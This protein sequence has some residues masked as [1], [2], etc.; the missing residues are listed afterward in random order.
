MATIT[1]TYC[2]TTYDDGT[3]TLH[4]ATEKGNDERNNEKAVVWEDWQFV[5]EGT[6]KDVKE[7]VLDEFTLAG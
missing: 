4:K 6:C 7:Y 1:G 2:I 5:M 3:A